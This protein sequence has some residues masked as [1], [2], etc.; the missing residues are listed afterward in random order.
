MAR[1]PFSNSSMA[2]IWLANVCGSSRG[3]IHD[4]AFGQPDDE[5]P[6]VVNCPLITLSMMQVWPHEWQVTDRGPGACS[7]YADEPQMPKPEPVIAVDLFGEFNEE[8]V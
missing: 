5:L 2:E 8:P 1:A 4:S 6:A 7:E 3:C